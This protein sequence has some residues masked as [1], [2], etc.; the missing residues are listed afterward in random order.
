MCYLL[1]SKLHTRQWLVPIFKP[2]FLQPLK[3]QHTRV[4]TTPIIIHHHVSPTT[5]TTSVRTTRRIN[6]LRFI[7]K[8]CCCW[9]RRRSLRSWRGLLSTNSSVF[10][11]ETTIIQWTR[12]SNEYNIFGSGNLEGDLQYGAI[13]RYSL[14][15]LL[16]WATAMGL[17]IHL[18]E[19]RCWI[20]EVFLND[21]MYVYFL[22]NFDDENRCCCWWW[23]SDYRWQWCCWR[24]FVFGIFFWIFMNVDEGSV[25]DDEEEI[26]RKG[27]RIFWIF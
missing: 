21:F 13:S 6:R 10:M 27:W 20:K 18:G 14:L 8:G 5:T 26:E 17:L 7:W 11:E 25:K 19:V 12:F 22:N 1:N 15:W 3:T 4:T 2:L 9:N 23:R 16:M 24:L